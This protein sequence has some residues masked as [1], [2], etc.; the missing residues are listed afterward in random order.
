MIHFYSILFKLFAF[1]NS[2]PPLYITIVTDYERALVVAAGVVAIYFGPALIGEESSAY[3]GGEVPLGCLLHATVGEYDEPAG[4]GSVAAADRRLVQHGSDDLCIGDCMER[5]VGIVAV[6]DGKQTVTLLLGGECSIGKDTGSITIVV[7]NL[8][9]C[10]GIVCGEI[11]YEIF[12]SPKFVGVG[13][14]SAVMA[15]HGL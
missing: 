15:K 3:H 5:Q 9:A 8:S 2:S 10:I 14:S 13:V 6:G 1:L 4:G 7:V 12:R 11:L